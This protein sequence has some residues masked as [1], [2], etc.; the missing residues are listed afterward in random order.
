V[1]FNPVGA[2]VLDIYIFILFGLNFVLIGFMVHKH[3][4]FELY[5]YILIYVFILVE[6]HNL[7]IPKYILRL[8]Y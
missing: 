7:M 1:T 4:Y 8:A 6:L 3:A 2:P 5:F